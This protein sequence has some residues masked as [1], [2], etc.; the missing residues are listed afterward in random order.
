MELSYRFVDQQSNAKLRT[1]NSD[2]SLELRSKRVPTKKF[3]YLNDHLVLIKMELLYTKILTKVLIA[4]KSISTSSKKCN[5][6]INVFVRHSQITSGCKSIWILNSSLKT[7]RITYFISSGS[8]HVASA[9]V[10][11]AFVFT[12]TKSYNTSQWIPR[13]HHR[14]PLNLQNLTTWVL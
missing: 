4:S 3:Q 5:Q 2:P 12:R 1:V 9:H 6:K 14:S 13:M 8:A 10:G 7:I 11:N